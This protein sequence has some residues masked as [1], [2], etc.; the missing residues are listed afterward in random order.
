MII[1]YAGRFAARYGSFYS[2]P[3]RRF[4]YEAEAEAK[5]IQELCLS[6]RKA[7]PATV[8]PDELF[9]AVTPMD[10]S[11]I[12]HRGAEF[13][14]AGARAFLL[15]SLSEDPGDRVEHVR[16]AIIVAGP[17]QPTGARA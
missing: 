14:T 10:E 3:A 12:R 2:K 13:H 8:V 6:G 1:N 7:E 16:T 4:D 15:D 9:D 5:A 17:V 11:S